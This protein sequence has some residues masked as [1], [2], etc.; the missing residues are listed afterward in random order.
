MAEA[1]RLRY[2]PELDGLRAIAAYAVVLFHVGIPGVGGG[3]LGV[4]VF[5]VLSG[6]LTASI[7][8]SGRL[9][10]SAFMVRRLRRIWP[11]LLFVCAVV[12]LGQ[13][14]AGTFDV[15]EIVP[16]ALYLSDFTIWIWGVSGPISHTWTLAIEMQFYLLVA[17]LGTTLPKDRF[18]ALCLVFFVAVTALRV[19]KGWAGDWA[20]GYHSPMTHSSG[21]F[22]G[23]ILA[24]L[25]LDR[26]R[27][28]RW[29]ALASFALVLAAFH[30]GV[31]ESA[32]ALI[33]WV[34]VAEAGSVGLVA[35]I[36]GGGAAT[37]RFL[38]WEPLR[39]LGLWSYGIYLWHLPIWT[40]V[41]R[42]LDLWACLAVT[43]LGATAAAA[44][45]YVLIELPFQ[46]PA[47]R[48]L[49]TEEAAAGAR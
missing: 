7:A 9:D 14:I 15:W 21:L 43:A 40:V 10:F 46:S 8:L 23:A 30:L 29:I 31:N 11:L 24:T 19:F 12:G 33:L 4:D 5:F 36:A 3:F 2:V 38:A 18:R 6:Y 41:W 47:S 39:R 44:L 27:G 28:A 17:A 42:H 1:G 34:G 26:L 16:P 35:A 22:A 25:P 13:M 32:E 45:T 37:M 48:R 20:I 49:R